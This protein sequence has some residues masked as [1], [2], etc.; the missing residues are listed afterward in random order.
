LTEPEA[1]AIAQLTNDRDF[2]RVHA[3]HTQGEVIFW[4]YQGLEPPES[5][6]IVN[7]YERVS[8]YLAVQ[9]V[10]SFAGYKDWFIQNFRRPGFTVELGIGVNPLPAG[11]FSEMYE[12]SLGI[13][14]ANLYLD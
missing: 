11:Q 4:G 7:E 14:L 1:I 6:G 13:L 10:D 5:E 9:Y 2:L 3:F 12:K 8:G